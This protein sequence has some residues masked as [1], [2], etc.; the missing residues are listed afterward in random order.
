MAYV[1]RDSWIER[2]KLDFT[3]QSTQALKPNGTYTIDG[4]SWTSENTAAATS[5]DVTNGTGLVFVIPAGPTFYNQGTRTSPLIRCD[6]TDLIGDLEFARIRALRLR[7]RILLTNVNEQAEFAK[8]GWERATT[9]AQFH[10]LPGKGW[11]V[12]SPA[13]VGIQDQLETNSLASTGNETLITTDDVIECI[14]A[15]GD[16]SH[17][18][19]RATYLDGFPRQ[20]T[21]LTA[22][23]GAIGAN[24]MADRTSAHVRAVFNAQP[25]GST[26]AFTATFT[27]FQI[28]ELLH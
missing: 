9:P 18:I 6:F 12:P 11:P 28:H 23:S 19:R 17:D 22:S 14:W 27:H 4:V 24:V 13:G 21:F 1:P 5:V 7:T 25:T 16:W 2:Y 8:F 10:C 26:T 3:A 15:L 20:T